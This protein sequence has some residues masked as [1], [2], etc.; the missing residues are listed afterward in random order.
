M[1]FSPLRFWQVQSLP[2]NCTGLDVSAYLLPRALWAS[3]RCA[4]G[5]RSA[6]VESKPRFNYCGLIGCL[7]LRLRILGREIFELKVLRL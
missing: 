5:V 6:L 1:V 2:S 4:V 3:K 7:K